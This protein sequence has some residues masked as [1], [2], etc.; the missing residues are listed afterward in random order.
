MD[1]ACFSPLVR[2]AWTE[3][4]LRAIDAAKT[5]GAPVVNMHMNPG[6]RVTLPDRKLDLYERDYD[7]YLQAMTEF[8]DRCEERA[9]GK[10]RVSVENTGGWKEWE[11]QAVDRLLE[12]PA[13][14]LTWDI[15]HSRAAEEVDAPFLLER[16]ARLG[17]FHIHDC[18]EKS[19]HLALGDGEIDLDARLTLAA[20]L[21][22]RCVLEAKTSAALEKSVRWLRE[23]GWMM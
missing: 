22:A 19:N 5:L 20:E 13:F 6:V 4:A 1:P 2:S 3:T 11:K 14:A 8:R 21:G 18:R 7:L 23:R 16:S 10:V 15:G 17:H 12:S 9:D